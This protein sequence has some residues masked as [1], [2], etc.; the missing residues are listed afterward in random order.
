MLKIKATIRNDDDQPYSFDR[1]DSPQ[2]IQ[3]PRDTIAQS[4]SPTFGDVE[5][6]TAMSSAATAARFTKFASIGELNSASRMTV[7]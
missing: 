4:S 5:T 7:G 3:A 1:N 2:A 6:K